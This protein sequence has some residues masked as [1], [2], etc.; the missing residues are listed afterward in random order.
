MCSVAL[1]PYN[2]STQEAEAAGFYDFL[3]KPNCTMNTR[4]SR[5]HIKTL[6]RA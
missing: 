1:H 2:A 6:S 3:A 5:L 4:P